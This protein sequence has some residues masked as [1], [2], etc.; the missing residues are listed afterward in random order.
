MDCSLKKLRID[1]SEEFA[2]VYSTAYHLSSPA[3]GKP[4][5]SLRAAMENQLSQTLAKQVSGKASAWADERE[6]DFAQAQTNLDRAKQE[7]RELEHAIDDQRKKVRARRDKQGA[8]LRKA[9]KKVAQLEGEIKKVRKKIND[10]RAARYAL[11]K[12]RRPPGT[13]RTKHGRR[14]KPL[15]NVRPF[16]RRREP[17]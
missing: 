4:N 7:V 11:S 2:G 10:N 14:P 3:A 9:Q 12:R 8:G 1:T 6:R 16:T 17:S 13:E 15:A 5:W